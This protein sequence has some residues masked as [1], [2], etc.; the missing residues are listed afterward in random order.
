M[1]EPLKRYLVF[2]Y[3][4]YYPA[5]GWGDFMGSFD[6]IEEAITKLEKHYYDNCDV[7]DTT[8]GDYVEDD[9]LKY[10]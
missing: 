1:S 3:D 8:T 9:R 4:N 6:T 5:G 7:I 10:L 2:A